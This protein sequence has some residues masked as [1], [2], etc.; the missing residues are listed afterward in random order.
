MSE[1]IGK[2][3]KPLAEDFKKSRKLFLVPLVYCGPDSPAP[4]AEKYHKYWEQVEHQINE[5]EAKLGGISRIYHEFASP[6][7]KEKGGAIKDLNEQSYH[8][9]EAR[10]NKGAVF[11][12]I[13]ELDLLA[14]LLDW[15][16]CLS[17][18]L[19]NPKVVAKISE[20]HTDISKQR[21]EH[22]ARQIDETLKADETGILFMTEN[23]K[24]QFPTDM[25]VFYVAP[26]VLD[27]IKRWVRD[28]SATPQE[29]EAE[30]EAGA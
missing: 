13:E 21:N 5:L 15:T 6:D 19:Q 3:E 8:I 11:E 25:E 7:M 29:D 9:A 17:I 23:Y 1:E 30:N 14:E 24:V 20:Y 28:Y 4:Y 26:P 2:I 27:E 10:L 16:R 12:T 18:G 22:I